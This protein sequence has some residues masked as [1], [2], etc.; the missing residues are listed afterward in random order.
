[1]SA[2]IQALKNFTRISGFGHLNQREVAAA[3]AAAIDRIEEL[4]RALGVQVLVSWV[5]WRDAGC[6]EFHP[7][8]AIAITFAAAGFDPNRDNIGE[9]QTAYMA[10]FA[11]AGSKHAP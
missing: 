3:C 7:D 8:S 9:F 11:P 2:V 4:E 1:M 6:A 5:E 10:R